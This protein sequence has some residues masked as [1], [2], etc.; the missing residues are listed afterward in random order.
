MQRWL[1]AVAL[2]LAAC[3]LSTYSRRT[4]TINVVLEPVNNSGV[5]GYA[6]IVRRTN[7]PTALTVNLQG[8]RPSTEYPG[9]AIR[10]SCAQPGEPREPLPTLRGDTRGQAQTRTTTVPDSVLQQ[11][12]ALRYL[13]AG[14]VVAC[15]TIIEASFPRSDTIR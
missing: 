7:E 4:I 14:T 10:G 1:V 11:G 9:Q 6:Q 3:D 13:Q 2:G 8:L 12:F 15:G 5:S